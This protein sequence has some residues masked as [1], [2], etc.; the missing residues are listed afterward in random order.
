[1]AL[2][3][4]YFRAIQ[5]GIG[6]TNV[7]DVKV[8]EV[9]RQFANDFDSSIGVVYDA[10]RNDIQQD[11]IITPTKESNKCSVY[12]RPDEELNIGDIIM[13]NKLHWLVIDKDFQNDIYNA[14]TIVQCNRI[15]RWQN[16]ITLE[17]IERW[18]FCSDPY[19][20]GIDEGNVISVQDVKF[21][22]QIPYDSETIQIMTDKRLMLDV[23]NGKADT[24][25]VISSNRITGKYQDIDGGFIKWIIQSDQ[26]V[27]DRDNLELMICD[28]IDPGTPP[29]P[30]E[31]SVSNLLKCEIIGRSNL[32]IGGSPR[33]Y[34]AKF[35]ASD[36]VTEVKDGI[37]PVWKL[38]TPVGHEVYYKISLSNGNSVSICA[39]EY[40]FL[41]GDRLKLV[42]SNKDGLYSSAEME[43]E[44]ISSI[45]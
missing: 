40:R 14:G 37:S 21:K 6:H 22:I 5:G 45:G 15:I 27:A 17:I 19:S 4:D 28:Y 38:V 31:P 34:T 10:L 29:E 18:C 36:G 12:T 42:L 43:I 9:R 33:N 16:P 7:K 8:A 1:M 23:I 44:V 25:K 35:Y 32:R 13:W 39:E 2:G 24:Y 11:F 20:S 3:I 41:V 26:S 30:P